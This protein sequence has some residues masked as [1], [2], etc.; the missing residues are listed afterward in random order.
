MQEEDTD[1]MPAAKKKVASKTEKQIRKAIKELEK[2]TETAEELLTQF[3]DIAGA[4][5]AVKDKTELDAVVAY[6]Q[7]L[8]TAIK[9]K[10]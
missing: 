7:G 5:E 1:T 4:Q 8:G 3:T 10:R 6:L 2:D 9:T